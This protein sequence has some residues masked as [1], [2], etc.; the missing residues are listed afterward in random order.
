MLRRTW[1]CAI[2]LFVITLFVSC[3]SSDEPIGAAAL[4]GGCLINTD[5]NSPLVCAFRRCHIECTESRD[6][7]PGQRCVASDRPF[8]VCQ[9]DQERA[10]TRDNDCP[11]NMKCGVDG[12]CRD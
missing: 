1:A 9:L 2:A 7:P 4:A 6:C 11:L 8:K 3:G 10:C 5:C 12:E